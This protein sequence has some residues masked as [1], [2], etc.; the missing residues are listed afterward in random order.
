MDN[1]EISKY[2]EVVEKGIEM[3]GVDPELCRSNTDGQWNLKRGQTELWIDLWYVE[4]EN[5]T[6]F[7]VMTPLVAIPEENKEVFYR[8]LLDL[9]YQMIGSHFVTYKDGVYVKITKEAE[10]L[11]PEE[12][13]LILNRIGYYGEVF[14]D[15]FI[16]KF[17]TRKLEHID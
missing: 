2:Y 10:T 4:Q 14:E 17:N 7:Q 13:V 3:A 11:S 8:E 9:N 6:Y 5:H 16:K 12:L 1:T 15:G